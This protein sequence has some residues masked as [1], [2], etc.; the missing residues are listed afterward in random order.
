MASAHSVFGRKRIRRE[1]NE[2]TKLRILAS[3]KVLLP[4]SQRKRLQ[5]VMQTLQAQIAMINIFI[6]PKRDRTTLAQSNVIAEP[7]VLLGCSHPAGDEANDTN[8][9]ILKS[10]RFALSLPRTESEIVYKQETFT[11]RRFR[12]FNEHSLLNL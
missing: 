9:I 11:R 3:G 1:T 12:T 4:C 7:A 6:P 8:S 10:T 2:R 5:R